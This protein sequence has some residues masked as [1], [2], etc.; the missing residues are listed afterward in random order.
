[1]LAFPTGKPTKFGAEIR[2]FRVARGVRT[3]D[4]DRPQ[5]LVALTGPPTL[6]LARTLIVPRADLGPGAEVLGRGKPRHIDADF[7]DQVLGRPLTDA[8]DRVE[9]RN[10]LGERTAQRL[11]LGFTLG[12]TLFEELNI[13]EDVREQLSMVG[14]E[15]PAES[16]LEV[17]LLLPEAAFRELR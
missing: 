9:E 12:D 2:P 14:P 8:R 13:R 7:R 3:F 15:A 6:A 5:P 17:R 4:E 11:K 1:M 10:D 16:C